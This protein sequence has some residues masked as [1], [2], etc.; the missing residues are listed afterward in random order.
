MAAPVSVK[1]EWLLTLRTKEVVSIWMSAKN[2]VIV[3]SSA[4]TPPE[5]IRADVG[6]DIHCLSPG[7][8]KRITVRIKSQ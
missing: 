4:S 2:G 1:K 8:A 3:T 6:R 5:V 7:I